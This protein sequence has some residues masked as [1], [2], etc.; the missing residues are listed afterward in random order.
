MTDDFK[1]CPSCCSKNIL[2]NINQYSQR[3]IYCA[4]CGFIGPT[5]KENDRKGSGPD[6]Y[7]EWERLW[8]YWNE[9]V[10]E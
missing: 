3:Y 2:E 7:I 9:G 1:P 6:S 8:D 10:K 4:D 5:L